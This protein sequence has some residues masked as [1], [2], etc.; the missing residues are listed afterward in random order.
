M[1]DFFEDFFGNKYF[2]NVNGRLHVEYTDGTKEWWVNGQLHRI[3]GP[4]YEDAYGYKEW[5]INDK[6]HR[7]DGPAIEE[8][9]GTKEWYIDSWEIIEINDFLDL[10]GISY[11]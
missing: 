5:R 9:D 7:L 11:E 3:D 1:S 8:S 4:A 10:L 6:I 2:R